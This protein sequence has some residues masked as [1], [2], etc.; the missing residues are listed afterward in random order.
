M[1]TMGTGTSFSDAERSKLEINPVSGEHIQDL[2]KLY[3]TPPELTKR[4]ADMPR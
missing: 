3:K 1:E 2:V 4:L